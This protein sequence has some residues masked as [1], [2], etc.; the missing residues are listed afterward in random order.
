MVCGID[1]EF[2]QVLVCLALASASSEPSAVVGVQPVGSQPVAPASRL[3]TSQH[4][5]A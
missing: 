1:C 4:G 5:A 3:R 2:V